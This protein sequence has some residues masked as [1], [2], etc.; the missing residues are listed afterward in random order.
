MSGIKRSKSLRGNPSMPA[1]QFRKMIQIMKNKEIN[2]DIDKLQ[3]LY[4][5]KQKHE[6]LQEMQ[7][8]Q[9]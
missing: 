7:E 1:M 5:E 9:A 6:L 2:I 3:R 8:V 4:K